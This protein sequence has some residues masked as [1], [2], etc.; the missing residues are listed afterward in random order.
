MSKELGHEP[1]SI[2]H[3][4]EL[5]ETV[6]DAFSQ[7]KECYV[8]LVKGTKFGTSK[9]GIK[10]GYDRHLWIVKELIGSVE[11]GYEFRLN[12]IR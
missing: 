6:A 2:S 1:L 9:G 3:S 10:A 7:S 5:F 8:I 11:E 4:K 12:R